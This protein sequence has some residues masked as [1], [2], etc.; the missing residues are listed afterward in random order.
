MKIHRFLIPHIPSEQSF[1]ITKPDTVHQLAHVLRI[2]PGD[3]F[4]VFTDGGPDIVVRATAVSKK[5]IVVSVE[6]TTP[7]RPAPRCSVTVCMSGIRKERFEMA[8]EKLTEL[9]ISTFV[10]LVS[11]RTQRQPFRLDRLQMISDEALEQCGRSHRVKISEP[12][13]LKEALDSFSGEHIVL[14][15]QG[16]SITPKTFAEN[17][18]IYIGPEGGWSTEDEVLFSQYSVRQCSLGDTILR[19]ETAAITAAYA[20]LW[21]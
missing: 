21:A 12:L 5:E 9:G 10:P 13:T 8:L 11:H 1:T 20:L 4:A 18:V 17:V 6:S 7:P 15:E 2:A 16:E 14:S 3:H 19:A